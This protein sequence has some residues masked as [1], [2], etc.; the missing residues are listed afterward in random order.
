MRAQACSPTAPASFISS[1]RFI[2]ATVGIDGLSAETFIS[3]RMQ[4]VAH[5]LFLTK[6]PLQQAPQVPVK[7]VIALE[8]QVNNSDVALRQVIAGFLLFCLFS[9]ARFSDAARSS[10]LQLDTYKD[11]VLLEAVMLGQKTAKAADDKRAL[12]PL[13]SLGHTLV[14]PPWAEA[15]LAARTQMNMDESPF[16]M[17]AY[18]EATGKWLERPMTSAEGSC[19]LKDLL[20]LS[21]IPSSEADRFSAHSLKATPLA[22]VARANLLDSAEKRILGH[23][24]GPGERMVVTYSRDALCLVLGKLQSLVDRI[25]SGDDPDASRAARVHAIAAELNPHHDDELEPRHENASDSDMSAR[26][27]QPGDVQIASLEFEANAAAVPDAGN[28][29]LRFV[30]QVLSGIIHIVTG[31]SSLCAQHKLC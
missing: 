25:K 16:L 12:L 3:S 9:V 6:R 4:G 17:T 31:T 15:W 2:T 30:A 22:W 7:L 26:D 18:C 28:N 11:V 10:S 29:S 14:D 19:W 13:I 1:V 24:A 20:C 27:V 8:T 23:H 21:G 5:Q